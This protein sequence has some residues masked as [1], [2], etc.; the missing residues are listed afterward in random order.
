MADGSKVS[1]G[2]P[3][4]LVGGAV[5]IA[6]VIFALMQGDAPAPETSGADP[7]PE[8]AA[9]PV[10]AQDA[11]APAKTDSADATQAETGAGEAEPAGGDAG[12]DANDA[13]AVTQAAPGTAVSGDAPS[14]AEETPV[15]DATPEATET[16]S[17]PVADGT[18]ST[19]Q[20]ARD[21]E[22]DTA[23]TNAPASD[24]TETAGQAEGGDATEVVARADTAASTNLENA[25][26]E[27]PVELETAEGD[28]S[29]VAA[30][31]EADTPTETTVSEAPAAA[32]GTQAELATWT[33][34]P[35]PSPTTGVVDTTLGDPDT[36]GPDSG[37]ELAALAPARPQPA[38]E[39]GPTLD[40]DAQPDVDAA[41]APPPQAVVLAP[42]VPRDGVEGAQGATAPS[43]DVVRVDEAGNTVV[44]GSAEPN[45]EVE[46]LQNGQTV[47]T[48]TAS[49]RGEF[50]ALFDTDVQAQAQSLELASRASDGEPKVFSESS[51]IVLGRD[52]PS[53]NAAVATEE[54][55]LPPAV[56]KAT[57][58]AVTI[59][60]PVIGLADLERITLDSIS[61][62]N[63]GEVV[64]AGRGR[65][66]NAARIYVDRALNGEAPISVNGSWR[67]VL[68]DLEAG[69]Y[70]LR[71]DEVAP[72]GAVASRVESPFQRVYLTAEN[73]ELLTAEKQVVI[74]RGDNL[75]NIARVRYGDGFKYTTIYDANVDQIRDPDLIYPGQIFDVP[76][77]G[78]AA[79]AN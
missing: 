27:A 64:L 56:I 79:T 37:T 62:D 54:S 48:V 57:P 28:A 4:A 61:Y 50:V 77:L 6:I 78:E 10:V 12:T 49:A 73:L 30:S 1:I 58:E 67:L 65:P 8:G 76:K 22:T 26:A 20:V 32:D 51:V 7:A 74:Q 40:A 21:G 69:R 33:E 3:V 29:A 55:A 66:G 14:S 71:V 44:A 25:E 13:Q 68:S 31:A 43:F 59:L 2:A 19:P 45:S 11:E 38:P 15:A 53:I 60:Q 18:Q 36:N 46:I 72:D 9:T 70:V 63:A 75:W 52:V 47:A 41:R 34:A 17:Q 23:Q 5:G 42:E 39:A 16:E 24:A 35:E